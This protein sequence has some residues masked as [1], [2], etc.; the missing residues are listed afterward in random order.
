MVPEGSGKFVKTAGRGRGDTA[1]YRSLLLGEVPLL[2][3]RAPAE[4]AR[5]AFPSAT[6][7]PLMTDDERHRVGICYRREGR[8]AAIALGHA[9]V[10]G[11]RRQQRLADWVAFAGTHPDGFLYCFRGGMRSQIVQAWLGE[12]GVDYPRVH[13]GYRALRRFLLEALP[14]SLADCRLILIS[15]KTGTGKTRVIEALRAAIDLEGMA[16]HRGSAF[17]RLPQPQPTQINFENS[18]SIAFLQ[19][20]AAGRRT[21]FLEDE[22]RLIGRVAVPEVLR[23]RM[24]QA[25]QLVVEEDLQSRV[26]LVIEDYI[27]AL[28][29]QYTRICQATGPARHEQRL[30][31][32]LAKLRKRLGGLLHQ[33]VDAKLVEA[34]QRQ[35]SCGDLSA[36]R[37]WITPLLV[38]YYDPMYEYQ[39]QLRAGPR[40]GHGN[41]TAIIEQARVISG[42]SQ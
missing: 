30:R 16:R 8:E 23:Q 3:T 33:Q 40:L 19:H 37:Q 27:V 39:M 2:D 41:R 18:L 6:N 28:G 35:R 11:E 7:I 34:F 20:L 38:Q 21:L 9:L 29:Q 4:F 32:D 22:G 14:G 31:A 26:E 1:D 15:G 12:A 24:Q 25:A 5:G 10:A 13:G 36:H 17:G 42:S